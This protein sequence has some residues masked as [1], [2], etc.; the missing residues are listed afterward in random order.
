MDDPAV[1]EI[2]NL[3]TDLKAEL[4]QAFLLLE[5]NGPQ[6]LPPKLSKKITGK[7]WG[8]RV[9]SESGIGRSM[10]FTVHPK[11]VI[12]VSAFVKKSQKLPPREI[13]NAEARMKS[14]NILQNKKTRGS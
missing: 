12:V 4:M 11:K 8:L 10:Y 3:P 1:K 2:R 6:D 9:K 14:W 7:L 13:E 5:A